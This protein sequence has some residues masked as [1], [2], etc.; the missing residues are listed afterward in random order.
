[1]WKCHKTPLYFW[2]CSF[3]RCFSYNNWINTT[4]LQTKAEPSGLSSKNVTNNVI[5]NVFPPDLNCFS[6]VFFIISFFFKS[7]IIVASA[8]PI[9]RLFPL[10]FSDEYRSIF[11]K[12]SPLSHFSRIAS[13]TMNSR[14]FRDTNFIASKLLEDSC[15]DFFILKQYFT[16]F[17]R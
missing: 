11:L 5:R 8:Y 9:H 6:S 10:M 1:M 13:F 17:V 16:I 15:W 4:L 7:E 2:T 14:S 12:S 3:L